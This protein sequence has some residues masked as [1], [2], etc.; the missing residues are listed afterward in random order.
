MQN[1]VIA[2]IDSYTILQLQSILQIYVHY[3][4]LREPAVII[5]NEISR[6]NR[7]GKIPWSEEGF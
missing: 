1:E 3:D 4:E 5:A 6:R 2:K 7:L